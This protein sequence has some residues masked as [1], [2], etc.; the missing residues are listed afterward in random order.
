MDEYLNSFYWRSKLSSGGGFGS[1]NGNNYGDGD[2]DDGFGD[3]NGCGDGCGWDILIG[4]GW[5]HI[6]KENIR[7]SNNG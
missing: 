7:E 2:G 3:G 4:K 6:L 1:G 5:S